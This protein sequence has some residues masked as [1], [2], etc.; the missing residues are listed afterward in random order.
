MA[1]GGAIAAWP[2]LKAIR[3]VSKNCSAGNISYR[4]IL[5]D[6]YQS[7]RRCPGTVRRS[8]TRLVQEADHYAEMRGP[9]REV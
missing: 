8:R 1:V 3:A 5:I 6:R 9:S 4:S 7:G 2:V